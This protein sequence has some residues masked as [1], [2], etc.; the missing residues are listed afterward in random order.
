MGTVGRRKL[1]QS[2][3]GRREKAEGERVCAGPEHRSPR[4]LKAARGA[5][6]QS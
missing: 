4:P 1:A 3:A 2:E 5:R 6:V